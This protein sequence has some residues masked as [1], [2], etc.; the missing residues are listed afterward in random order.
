MHYPI[1]L[2]AES[3]AAKGIGGRDRLVGIV[4]PCKKFKDSDDVSGC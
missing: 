3:A 4:L 2:A 1:C